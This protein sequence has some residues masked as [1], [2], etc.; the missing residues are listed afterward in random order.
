MQAGRESDERPCDDTN[1]RIPI[2]ANENSINDGTSLE[3]GNLVVLVGPNNVG[4]SRSLT[5]GH[6][7]YM[8][9]PH[10]TSL[11]VDW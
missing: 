11:L 7:I 9:S 6:F 1:G 2:Q 3:P 4:K 5:K 10:K 8:R